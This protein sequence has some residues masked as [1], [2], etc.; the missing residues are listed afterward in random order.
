MIHYFSQ[1]TNRII[2]PEHTNYS[3]LAEPDCFFQKKTVINAVCL[4]TDVDKCYS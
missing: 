4:Y 2:S 1:F 3:I